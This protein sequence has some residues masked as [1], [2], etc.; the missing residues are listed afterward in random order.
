MLVGE[1]QFLDAFATSDLP[2]SFTLVSGP[3]TLD[4]ITLTATGRG[5]ITVRATQPGDATY[6]PATAVVRTVSV[7]ADPVDPGPNDPAPV[8]VAQTIDFPAPPPVTYGDPAV[9]LGASADSGLPVTLFVVSGPGVIEGDFLIPTGAGNIVVRA[10]QTGNAS[11]LPAPIVTLT[12]PVAKA[13]LLVTLEDDPIR[14]VGSDNP[15]LAPAYSGF[16]GEDTAADL[17]RRPVVT[18]AAKKSSPPGTY[19]IT[20]TGGL[21]N[22]Y[23]LAF[24]PAR[25]LTVVGYG[26]A[27]E[28]LL[29]DPE[30][31]L[32][33]GRLELTISPTASTFTGRL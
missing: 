4:G 32:P 19:P 6:L 10:T 17:D 8:R 28:A 3:G 29:L 5:T 24:G 33:V 21:D 30:T 2:V 20:L 1:I 26:G 25:T 12:I 22:N 11:Y 18:F 13:T 16:V 14:L 7:L 27:Y 23:T 9:F 31:S 15:P